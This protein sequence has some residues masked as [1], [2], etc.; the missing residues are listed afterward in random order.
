MTARTKATFIIDNV[1]ASRLTIFP[2][3][4]TNDLFIKSDLQINKVEIY[5]L[6]GI[7]LMQ[8]NFFTEKISVSSLPKGIFLLKVYTEKGLEVRKVFKD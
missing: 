4:A 3:P 8:E 5:S 1:N 2:N 6:S 7:L